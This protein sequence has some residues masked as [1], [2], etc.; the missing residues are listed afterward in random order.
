[1]VTLSLA[2]LVPLQDQDTTSNSTF[3]MYPR[4][5]HHKCRGT[6]AFSC[7]G[8]SSFH[9]TSV[10]PPLSCVFLF[11]SGCRVDLGTS[12]PLVTCPHLAIVCRL[13]H[14]KCFFTASFSGWESPKEDRHQLEALRKHVQLATMGRIGLTVRSPSQ[15]W[16]HTPP[17]SLYMSSQ[18]RLPSPGPW[19]L[20]YICHFPV[21]TWKF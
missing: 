18:P 7:L 9:P 14:S 6:Q 11:F 1:M 16:G 4:L 15:D 13:D 8:V 19:G 10:L 17:W 20:F 5:I 2:S 21:S 3:T 12:G